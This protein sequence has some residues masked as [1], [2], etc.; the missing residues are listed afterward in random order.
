MYE[1]VRVRVFKTLATT[2]LL[3]R[4]FCRS[5]IVTLR[6]WNHEAFF[7]ERKQK[8]LDD[9]VRVPRG[10]AAARRSTKE[11]L[12]TTVPSCNMRS[13]TYLH[14]PRK[15]HLLLGYGAKLCSLFLGAE[16]RVQHPSYTEILV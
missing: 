3:E 2:F 12:R 1:L 5:Y 4:V 11:S 9:D 15:S 13:H 7:T 6:Y 10:I 14:L 8:R 16:G